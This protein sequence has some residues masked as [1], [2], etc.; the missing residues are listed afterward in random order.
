MGKREEI[1]IQS[2]SDI[3]TNSSSEVFVRIHSSNREFMDELYEQ[4]DAVFGWN[5]ES[6]QTP[7]IEY[8][9]QRNHEDWEYSSERFE[10][11]AKEPKVD[12]TTINIEMPYCLRKSIEYHRAGI[13][14]LI[15]L[16]VKKHGV[17][18]LDVEFNNDF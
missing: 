13:Q 17:K 10:Y 3:I 11:D 1:A 15:D 16:G 9:G 18:D 14:K 7:V 4:I 5:Q 2:M 12:K 6:E 8:D